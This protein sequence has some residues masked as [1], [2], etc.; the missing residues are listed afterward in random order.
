MQHKTQLGGNRFISK[1]RVFKT[2]GP[3]AYLLFYVDPAAVPDIIPAPDPLPTPL[4]S[5]VGKRIDSGNWG[6][7]DTW[8]VVKRSGD[9][10][11]LVRE[12]II[13]A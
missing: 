13:Q 2:D 1:V 6:H 10:K 7:D 11:N 9:G 5:P 8:R 12:H 3:F 4:P